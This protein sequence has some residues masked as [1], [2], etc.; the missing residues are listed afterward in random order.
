MPSRR[1]FLRSALVAAPGLWLAPELVLADPYRPALHRRLGGAPVRIRGTVSAGGS[2]LAG[3]AVS[4]GFD[5]TVTTADG[6]YE[7]ISSDRQRFVFVS[8]PAGFRIPTTGM[9]TAAHYLPI[10]PDDS[11]DMTANFSLEPGHDDTEHSFLALGDTQ[12]QTAFEMQRLHAESVPDMQRVTARLSNAAFGIAV[13]DI[14]FDD[15][16]LFPEYERAVSRIG[17]PFFQAV[18]NHDLDM[19]AG[20]DPESVKTFERHFGPAYYSFDRGAVHYVVLDDVL[21]HG[22]GYIGHL[23]ADQLTWLARDLRLVED[24]RTV[25]VFLHIPALSSQYRRRGQDR[26]STSVSLTNRE[27]LYRLLEPFNAH[28]IS[29]HTHENEHVLEGGVHEH[30]LGT[31]CGA[32]WSD[33]ICHDGTP[34]GY[35]VYSVRGDALSWRYKS[36]GQVF[37]SQ[38]RLYAPRDGQPE[39]IANVWDW[40]PAWQVVWLEDGVQRGRLEP[41]VGLDPLSV[42]RFDG[43]DAPAHRTWVQPM[44]TEHLLHADISDAR[45][46]VVVEAV[47]RFSRTYSSRLS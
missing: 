8:T 13:G 42:S 22:S 46:S 9:G 26:P 15:L 10:R 39:L 45:G 31:T 2:G 36:T 34:N 12:T 18:G 21:W 41:R 25:V 43:D 28:L 4:D 27:L 19:D 40:D 47:D 3:V 32:W 7:L 38:M 35:A 37:S 30:V 24:G 17:I 33:D 29:G 6:S 5:V 1:T 23:S 14:M 16:S 11:G 20:V 44:P